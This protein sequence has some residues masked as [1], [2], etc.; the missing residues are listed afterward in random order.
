MKTRIQ[1]LIAVMATVSGLFLTAPA[2]RAEVKAQVLQIK[3]KLTEQNLTQVHV[4]GI[5]RNTESLPVRDVKIKVNLID[6]DKNPVRSFLLDPFEHMESAQTSTF[7][8]DYLLRDYEPLYLQATAELTYTPTSYFQIADWIINRNWDNLATWRIPLTS[9]LKTSER[10]QV[11]TSI[12]YLEHVP[13]STA[14]A[15]ADARRKINL[16]HYNYGKRLSEAGNQHEAILRLANVEKTSDY[17]I[18]AQALI[19]NIRVQ[20]IFDR[21]MEKAVNGHYRGAYRQMM[22][23]PENHPLSPQAKQKQEEWLEILKAKKIWLGPI[24]A[25]GGLS[26]DQKTVWLRRHHGPE[27]FTSSSHSDGTSARTW[28]YLDYSYYTF[29]N[30]GKL[31]NKLEY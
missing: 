2:A 14:K 10:T 7:E 19:D 18:D 25:P 16:I 13:R 23:I 29:D 26:K 27:G 6:P 15:Y 11:E 22:Y 5:V 21:A 9:T 1:K 28:W 24:T 4:Q 30:N 12:D 3:M 20:T 8:A 31:V 17:G